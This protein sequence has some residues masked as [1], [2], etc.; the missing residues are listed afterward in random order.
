MSLASWRA[1]RV[2]RGLVHDSTGGSPAGQQETAD[3]GCYA[4]QKC[5]KGFLQWQSLS[6]NRLSWGNRLLCFIMLA[7]VHMLR[8]ARFA[9]VEHPSSSVADSE[10]WLASI[11]KLF[12]TEVLAANEFVRK[13]DIFQGLFGARSPKPT[14]L[15]FCVGPD[16]DVQNTLFQGQTVSEMPRQLEMGWDRKAGEY[17]TASLK[18]YPGGLCAAISSVCQQWL[19]R[20]LPV[21][22]PSVSKPNSIAQFVHF[23]EQ[24]ERGFNFSAQRGSDF[25]R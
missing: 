7:F 2:S 1:P 3:H 11:W 10:A 18:N 21:T 25:H 23:T 19:D 16:L 20:Y 6:N 15:L 12:L 14:T 22:P 5:R 17:A 24:L 9:M 13:I 4:R 8:I